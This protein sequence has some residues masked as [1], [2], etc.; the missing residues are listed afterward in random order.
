M[1]LLRTAL[2]VM[3]L[4]ACSGPDVQQ[5]R[6]AGPA[7]DLPQYFDGVTDAWGI[8]QRR[9]R[10][11]ARRFHVEIAGTQDNGVLTLDERFRYD[12]GSTQQRIWRLERTRDGKWRGTAGDVKGV[13]QGEAAGYALRWQYALLLPVDGTTYE[14]QFDDWMFLV[15]RCTMIGRASMRKFG[16]E[17]GQV[18]LMFRKRTCPH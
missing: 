14:V 5:Y 17:L 16:F 6:D 12:D 18:T 3:L 10:D 7:L 4:T 11:V 9:N 2:L 13:A 15:D 8:F 1:K